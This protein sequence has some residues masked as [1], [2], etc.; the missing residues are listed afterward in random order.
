MKNPNI[1]QKII[2]LWNKYFKNN[3]DVYA[4]L[5]YE[6]FKKDSLLFIGMNPSFS[7][8]GFKSILKNTE[9]T[10]IDPTVFFKWSSISSNQNLIDD[11]IKIENYAQAKYPLYFGRPIEISKKLGINWQHIDLFLYKETSQKDFI[12]RIRNGKEL[13]QFA[14]DQITLFEEILV[15]IDPRCIVVSNAFASELL[16]EYIKNDLSWDENRGFRWFTKES[17][18]IPVFFSS[19]LSGQRAL[20]RWSY[21]RLVWHIE[22]AIKISS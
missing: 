10:D 16:R 22:Q 19:M 11:C 7:I 15:E 14:L 4:P 21:E 12:E 3:P 6:E 17:K 1:N 13:N 5:F 8:H 18:K 2:E 9:Y 20:D